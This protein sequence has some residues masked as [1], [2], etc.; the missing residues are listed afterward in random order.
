MA[1]SVEATQKS[2][3]NAGGKLGQPT[4]TQNI[5]RNR[6]NRN[7]LRRKYTQHNAWFAKLLNIFCG[8]RWVHFF[9][10][11]FSMFFY[12]TLR[13]SLRLRNWL[14]VVLGVNDLQRHCQPSQPALVTQASRGVRPGVKQGRRERSRARDW[15]GT[16]RGLQVMVS[17]NKEATS[18]SRKHFN[19]MYRYSSV[20]RRYTQ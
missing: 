11:T 6:I 19:Y 5:N 9:Y 10:M 3:V 13:S 20:P 2:G 15:Y 16:R 1:S 14:D 4:E 7:T 8:I 12:R 18:D 17:G